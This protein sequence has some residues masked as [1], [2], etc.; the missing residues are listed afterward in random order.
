[1]KSI[2]PETNPEQSGAEA[3]K[4]IQFQKTNQPNFIQP[5]QSVP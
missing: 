1:M 2:K 5:N 3:N 4:P